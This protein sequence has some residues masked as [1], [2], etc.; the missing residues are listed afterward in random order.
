MR[1]QSFWNEEAMQIPVCQELVKNWEQIRDE[2][3]EFLS[4]KNPDTIDGNVF[5]TLTSQKIKVPKYEDGK[6][7]DDFTLISD[8]GPW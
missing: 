7:I 3:L 2:A 8:K 1:E 4:S 6:F 5:T